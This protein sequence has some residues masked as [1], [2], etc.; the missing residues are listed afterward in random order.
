MAET[1]QTPGVRLLLVALGVTALL[2]ATGTGAATGSSPRN[3]VV[4]YMVPLTGGAAANGLMEA[5]GFNL[6]L[7][8]F[9]SNVAGHKIEVKYV[10]TQGDPA[11]ALTLARSLVTST[12]IDFLEGPL[13]ANEQAAIT[14]YLASVGIPFDDL[15]A[16]STAQLDNYGKLDL[17]YASGWLVTTPT[18][19]GA[20]WAYKVKGW[21]HMTMISQ[22][23]SFG[24]VSAGSFAQTFRK[25]GGTIDKFIWYPTG[26]AD[27]APFISQIPS[28]TQAV[29]ALGV[30][31][32]SVRLLQAYASFGL[33][34]I[35]L[36]GATTLTDQSALPAAGDAA[37]G[38]YSDAQYC[39][40]IPSK[41]NKKF[42]SAYFAKYGAYPGYYSDAG[43]TKARILINTLKRLKGDVTN[44]KK[45]TA[46]LRSFNIVGP[47]GPVKLDRK[48]WVP[49]QNAYI[50]Q[51]KKVDGALRNV[52]IS[53][54][55]A[56]PLWGAGGLSESDWYEET[57]R[58]A[59][60]R[61]S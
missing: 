36:M 13:L 56:V 50:C 9:G 29:W 6:G 61:P 35:P 41:I 20:V 24:W 51:V 43:Y 38:T 19:I 40:G 47:R 27:M 2:A 11:V 49:I 28:D 3:I 22:D 55:K 16:T 54:Y 53:T 8:H 58:N 14:P 7:R 33:K 48:Y 37:I 21:R 44:K 17:G 39:D 25:L 15:S 10:D 5:Q 59:A 32:T 12:K 34:K 23:Y 46:A 31:A 45:L 52:P 26:T 1:R 60:G 42:V 4:G 18:S 30:G 57:K